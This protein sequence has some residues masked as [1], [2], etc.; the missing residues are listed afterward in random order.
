MGERAA[1]T[2]AV[3]VIAFVM[4]AALSIG[5]SVL[6]PVVFALFIIAL[7]WP[8][9]QWLQTMTPR[10]V[11]LLLSILIALAVMIALSSLIVWS[12]G[13]IVDWFIHNVER[14]K[15]SFENATKWLEAHDIFVASLVTEHFSAAW[16][17]AMIRAAAT[18]INIFIGF[19]LVVLIYVIMGLAE[20]GGF[21]KKLAASRSEETARSLLHAGASIAQKLRR[22]MMVRTAAS[23]ATGA[24]VFLFAL[25]IGL[26]R[27]AAWGVLTF[28]LNYLPYIGPAVATLLPALFAYAQFD[29][30]H[31]ALLVL[32]V[33]SM[34]QLV[35]GS[36]LEPAFSGSALAMSPTVVVFSVLLWTFLWGLPGAFIG[37]PIAIA[38]LTLCEQ[39]PSSRWVA[40][41]LSDKGPPDKD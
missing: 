3:I 11:A 29:S 34:V 16:V 18:R 33:L 30:G 6:E 8:L 20:A 4:L 17:L 12:G 37:V 5:Q 9:Q 31:A 24:L 32:G 25:A 27:A 2:A 21:E 7:L 39:F 38:F 41:L 19:A 1:D 23:L 10:P 14:V 22:Y 13:E 15:T 35:I 36:G 40:A 26:D 28:A